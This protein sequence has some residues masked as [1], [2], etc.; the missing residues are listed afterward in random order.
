[1]PLLSPSLVPTPTTLRDTVVHEHV[2][3]PATPYHAHVS[4][5]IALAHHRHAYP[6]RR[7]RV[8]AVP[9]RYTSHHAGVRMCVCACVY[10]Q[11]SIKAVHT[12]AVYL[13]AWNV[14]PGGTVSLI[15]I[16]HS[17]GGKGKTGDPFARASRYPDWT[18]NSN[19][20]VD[21]HRLALSHFLIVR[22]LVRL[23]TSALNYSTILQ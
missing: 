10:L 18:F 2:L 21:F 22:S 16:G 3:S 11:K 14:L 1:L 19:S 8:D 23:R 20:H 5:T 17:A 9:Q 4:G 15:F 13:R 7:T 6:R 12:R